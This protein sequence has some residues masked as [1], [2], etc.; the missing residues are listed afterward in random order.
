MYEAQKTPLYILF[1]I[2][3]NSLVSYCKTLI[4]K[5]MFRFLIVHV[6]TDLV[7]YIASILKECS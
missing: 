1:D 7:S 5:V 3:I 4:K 2:S 6:L